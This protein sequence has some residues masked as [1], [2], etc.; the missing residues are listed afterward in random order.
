MTSI[1]RQNSFLNALHDGM[2]MH[3]VCIVDLR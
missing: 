3:E 1:C 2:V